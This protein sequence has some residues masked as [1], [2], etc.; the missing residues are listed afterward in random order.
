[1]NPFHH[2]TGGLSARDGAERPRRRSLRT[3]PRS[4]WMGNRPT[5]T[6]GQI[7][8]SVIAK[9]RRANIWLAPVSQSRNI[10]HEIKSRMRAMDPG[11]PGGPA[12]TRRPARSSSPKNRGTVG[13]KSTLAVA[14]RGPPS[15]RHDGP[16]AQL[17]FLPY[18]GALPR[19]VG[20]LR[21]A[22]QH[23]V[24]ALRSIGIAPHASVCPATRELP[25]ER[26][27][28]ISLMCDVSNCRGGRLGQRMRLH[29]YGPPP[30]SASP[31]AR[32]PRGGAGSGCRPGNVDCDG[33]G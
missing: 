20:K 4:T 6:T 15:I 19:A 9:E 3:F 24:A 11:E 8:F 25:V 22:D 1:M 29:S 28:K 32:R 27:R 10:T 23:S 26:Q 14:E 7:R 13:D 31:K 16:A 21:P 2:S 5:V 17:L 18:P 33:V 30:G 12:R